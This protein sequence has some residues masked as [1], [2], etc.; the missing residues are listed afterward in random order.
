M[1]HNEHQN[2]PNCRADLALSVVTMGNWPVHQRLKV[3]GELMQV[4]DFVTN[5]PMTLAR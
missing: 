1:L 3:V 2:C 5:F 4:C